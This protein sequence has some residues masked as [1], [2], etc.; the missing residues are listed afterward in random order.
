MLK[1]LTKSKIGFALAILFAISL[2][3]I[4]GGDRYS[5]LFGSDNV[6]AS[7]SGTPIS[8]SK[9][10][11]VM[12][13]NVNQYTQMFGRALNANEIQ[14]F[15]IHS[16][17][18]SQLVNNAVF[19]N[20]FD[21]QQFIVDE[22]VVAYETKKRFPNLYNANNKL[23]ETALNAFLS[24]QSLK[25][26]DLVKII[27]YE[28]R[29]RVFDKLFFDVSYPNK[30]QK[31]IEK[32]NN[33]SRNINLIQF[34]I[35]DFQLPNFNDL[36]ISIN[37][38]SIGEFFNQNLN[39][40]MVPEKRS[41]SYIVI[42]P[43]NY[44]EQFTP[45][46][47]QIENYFNNN[48][49]IFLEPERRDFI[50]FNFKDLESANEF[51]KNILA[52]SSSEIIEYANNKNI[53]FNEFSKV[54][55][56]EVLE[57][58]SNAI[59]NLEKNQVSEVVETALA[60]HIVVLNNIYPEKESTLNESQQEITDTLLQVEVESF[61]MDLKNKISQQILDGLSLNEIAIDNSLSIENLKNA[62]RNNI[63]AENDLIKNQ[64]I[65]KGFAS[66]KDFVSD[67]EELDDSRSF[68][69]N[70]DNIENERPYELE[71]IFEVVSSDWID[72]LKIESI[73]SQIDKILESSKSLEEIANFV[74]KEILNEDM[75]LDSNLF[76]TTVKNTV[77]TDEINQISLS[78]SNKD[79]Y[80]SQLK[81]ISFP[82]EETN[83]AQ[84]ISMLSELR[85]NFGAEIIKNKNI[86]TNDN[87][88]QAL[89][90]QY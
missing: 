8:T 72:S 38:S 55:E 84:Q 71:E 47:S 57:N 3:L 28:A 64:V 1:K 2:F 36:D 17:A 53:V 42:D 82:K 70:V 79:I 45:S 65:A 4:R 22:T 85:S 54:S 18:L 44:T 86:S 63:Q 74:K 33:H 43:N 60:K 58:L 23:N 41:M 88:I 37:N 5:G 68:I 16:M 75:K 90:S 19:E 89:I 52:L 25:I 48:K 10:L 9:F 40:Y 66:N 83:N 35:D 62:E 73:N 7:V 30:M 67:I 13:M 46:S 27:D 11:R 81:Q 26:D 51:K 6:V 31:L 21:G 12:T 87:L 49:S 78:I 76:P 59:F 80:I 56:N 34:N 15:Q 24:K 39:S 69:V 32:H 20:E 77:F 61:I 14:A 29:S 50:Q